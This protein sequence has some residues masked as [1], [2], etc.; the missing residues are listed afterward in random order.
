[1]SWEEEASCHVVSHPRR[2]SGGEELRVVS[3]AS[4]TA[5]EEVNPINHHVNLEVHLLPMSPSAEPLPWLTP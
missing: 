4:E 3:T 1:M 2:G 5:W